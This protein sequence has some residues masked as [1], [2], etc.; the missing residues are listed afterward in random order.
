MDINKYVRPL[1]ES[2]QRL[3]KITSFFPPTSPL[4]I[5]MQSEVIKASLTLRGGR[6]TAKPEKKQ[7]KESRSAFFGLEMKKWEV[8]N[9]FR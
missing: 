6:P 4:G 8:S 3:V 2:L 9:G 7:R 5:R 1:Q